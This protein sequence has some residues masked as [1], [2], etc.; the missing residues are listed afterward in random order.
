MG[1]DEGRCQTQRCFG[2]IDENYKTYFLHYFL[3]SR[4]ISLNI[5]LKN[6]SILKK[7]SQ[8]NFYF[9]PKQN[10]QWPLEFP[11]LC[12]RICAIDLFMRRYANYIGICDLLTHIWDRLKLLTNFQFIYVLYFSLPYFDYCKLKNDDDAFKIRFFR[13]PVRHFTTYPKVL[14]SLTKVG[15]N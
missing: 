7:H 14:A 1:W 6:S 4:Y 10:N 9:I 15:A 3:I 8:Y 13:H 2:R 5:S 11:R 12:G